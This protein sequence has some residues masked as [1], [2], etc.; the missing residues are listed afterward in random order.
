MQKKLAQIELKI[1]K[2][3][4]ELQKCRRNEAGVVDVSVSETERE[5][6]AGSIKSATHTK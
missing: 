2:I 5:K 4:E 6:K 3:K 1:R